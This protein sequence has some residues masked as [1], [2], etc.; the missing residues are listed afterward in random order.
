MKAA[1]EGKGPRRLPPRAKD[2]EGCPRGQR[3]MKA[4]PEGKGGR[5]LP[6]RAKEEEGYPR[7]QRTKQAAKGGGRL[8]MGKGR[9]LP[10]AGEAIEG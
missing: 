3:T 1:P 8:S 9:K 6:P 7:G 5:R 10:L 2:D 4:A